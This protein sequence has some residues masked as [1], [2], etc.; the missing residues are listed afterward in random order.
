MPMVCLNEFL[1]GSEADIKKLQT[2][3][4]SPAQRIYPGKNIVNNK[5]CC[6]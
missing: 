5:A 4:Q 1:R 2:V 6:M 3:M